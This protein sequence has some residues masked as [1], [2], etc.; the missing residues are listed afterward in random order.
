MPTLTFATSASPKAHNLILASK[1]FHTTRGCQ[2]KR[3]CP[4]W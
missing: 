2:K 3:F 4:K 1:Y